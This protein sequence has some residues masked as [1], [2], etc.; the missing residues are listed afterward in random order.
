MKVK[1]LLNQ[2]LRRA[3][4]LLSVLAWTACNSSP[5]TAPIEM[6]FSL[7]QG[8]ESVEFDFRVK[9]TYGYVVRLKIFFH[10]KEESEDRHA[11]TALIDQLGDSF[12]ADGSIPFVRVPI[13][14]RIRV[15]SI[16]VQGPPVD[17]DHT[18]DQL[19][20]IDASKEFA[21]KQVQMR[22][23]NQKLQ[24]GTYHIRVD[25]LHPVPEFADRSVNLFLLHAWQ[26]K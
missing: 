1:I 10:N 15:K 2:K 23:N 26:G 13:T 12:A 16:E 18:T 22:L 7:G 17:F 6:P 14:L 9:E 25:N 20:L 19:G 11:R 4:G 3:L 8:G 5:P 21:T 24:P